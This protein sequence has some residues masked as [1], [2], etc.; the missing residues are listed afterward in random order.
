M[1]P[2]STSDLFIERFVDQVTSHEARIKTGTV[3]A[4]PDSVLQIEDNSDS[5]KVLT[6]SVGGITAATTRTITVPDYD[7]TLGSGVGGLKTVV[8]TGGAFATPIVLTAADSGKHYLLD[9]AAGLDFTLPAIVTANV[10]MQFIFYL[11]TEP[12]SNSY[13]WT[14]QAADLLIGQV[15]IYD[16]DVAEGSTEALLQIMRPDGSDD[17]ITT[18]TGTD[19]TQGSL[20]GGWLEFTAITATRWFVRGSLIG[21]GALATIFS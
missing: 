9:D 7:L 3:L 2:F 20:V 1:T 6:F 19:D 14:A 4:I 5:T 13:R 18:I 12:T 17:L 21:D 15:V 8:D 10:G 11:Q 16:K